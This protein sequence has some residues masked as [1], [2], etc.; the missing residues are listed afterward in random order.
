MRNITELLDYYLPRR[1]MDEATVIAK[2]RQRHRLRE[3]DLWRRS[4]KH[5]GHP[6]DSTK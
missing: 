2:I 5:T 3:E 4:A 6:I 1:R